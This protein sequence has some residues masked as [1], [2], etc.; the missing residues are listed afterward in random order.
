MSTDSSESNSEIHKEQIRQK[1]KEIGDQADIL[2]RILPDITNSEE[3]R[4][5][6]QVIEAYRLE[7]NRLS[8]RIRDAK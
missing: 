6:E 1:I 2:A 5:I 3:K 4:K 8:E 7:A